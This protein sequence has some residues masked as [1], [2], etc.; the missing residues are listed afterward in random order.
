[1]SRADQ[2]KKAIGR[3]KRQEAATCAVHCR[4]TYSDHFARTQSRTEYHYIV[5][6][7]C[8]VKNVCL[9]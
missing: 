3:A 8:P 9:V 1:M 5:V 2:S 7:H 6:L 4:D